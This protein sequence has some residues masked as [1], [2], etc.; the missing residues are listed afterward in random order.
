MLHVF[1]V[2]SVVQGARIHTDGVLEGIFEEHFVEVAVETESI[3]GAVLMK[4]GNIDA[5]DILVL[6][7]ACYSASDLTNVLGRKSVCVEDCVDNNSVIRT[8]AYG[9]TLTLKSSRISVGCLG[10]G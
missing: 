8:V 7:K 2:L 4:S 3:Y 9:K 10:L 5:D 6:Y 1:L